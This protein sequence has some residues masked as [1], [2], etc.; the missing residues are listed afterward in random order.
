M[1]LVWE[2]FATGTGQEGAGGSGPIRR[3]DAELG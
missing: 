3:V 2:L 1:V